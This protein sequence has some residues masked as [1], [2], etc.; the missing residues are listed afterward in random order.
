MKRI[1][2]C[3]FYIFCLIFC[4]SFAQN[5]W[6][7]FYLENHNKP[8]METYP[9]NTIAIL[10]N[11]CYV[12]NLPPTISP[13][14]TLNTNV[15]LFESLKED[16][17]RIKEFSFMSYRNFDKF[18]RLTPIINK[19]FDNIFIFNSSYLDSYGDELISLKILNGDSI[20]DFSFPIMSDGKTF[21]SGMSRTMYPIIIDNFGNSWIKVNF[22][23]AIYGKENSRTL[24]RSYY[25]YVAYLDYAK[26]SK[27]FNV[28]PFKL[29]DRGWRSQ[30]ICDNQNRIWTTDSTNIYCFDTSGLFL[31][32]NANEMFLDNQFS[33]FVNLSYDSQRNIL[34]FLDYKWNLL[35]YDGTSWKKE[36]MPI[37]PDD[38]SSMTT[39][40]IY[41]PACVDSLGNFWATQSGFR[42]LYKRTPD[43]KWYTYEIEKTFKVYVMQADESGRIFMAGFRYDEIP[44][45]YLGIF[46]P[47]KAKPVPLPVEDT[48]IELLIYKDIYI[49]KIYPNP[50]VLKATIEFYIKP[51]HINDF[52]I[53]L[54]NML[55][56]KVMN[57][58][59]YR[60][61]ILYDAG[62]NY[63]K[64]DLNIPNNLSPGVYYLCLEA[65][66]NR[67]LSP[68]VI[69]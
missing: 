25:S 26:G 20:I 66:G 64:V 53:G 44:D 32:L 50:A 57:M 2:L 10:K 3:V 39:R 29:P 40:I 45:Y 60:I 38:S 67:Q 15:F 62:I 68:L 22:D 12:V 28:L 59:D 18:A 17:F 13:L 41:L 33:A 52:K 31:A 65:G 8:S 63:A 43:G 11:K 47:N 34:Y 6:K 27:Q 37:L 1:F 16:S 5:E 58:E 56:E 55:G 42:Y 24:V 51:E 9:W 30:A 23:T 35:I 46:Y 4:S 49:S 61:G 14:V 7:F 19:P 69:K 48:K 54:Y 36:R 21:R